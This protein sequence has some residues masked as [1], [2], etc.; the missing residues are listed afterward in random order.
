MGATKT[1]KAK[2]KR[3]VAPLSGSSKGTKHKSKNKDKKG[4]KSSSAKDSHRHQHVDSKPKNT[5]GKQQRIRKSSDPRLPVTLLSGFLGAGKTTLL[6][7]IL[8]NKEHG[9]KC[10]VIVND[11]SSL[12]ID[13]QI[14]S[15]HKLTRTEEKLVQ[16]QNGCICCTLRGDLLEEVASIAE[17][18]GIDYLLIE[19]T[20]ISEPMQVAETFTYEF[21]EHAAAEE[22]QGNGR[23]ASLLKKGGLPKIARLDTCVSVVDALNVL[24]DFNTTDFITDRPQEA[25]NGEV[26]PSDERNVTDL[27]VDQIEFS[28]I[29][30]VNKT[31]LASKETV[32]KVLQLIKTL[33]PRAKIIS[34]VKCQVPLTEILNTHRFSFEE[35]IV[36]AGW[37]QSL[38]ESTMRVTPNGQTKNIPKPE[39]EEYGIS[40]FVYQR[41]RPFHPERLW[42]IIGDKFVVIQN[43]YEGLNGDDDD[44]E[45]NDEEKMDEDKEEEQEEEEDEEAQPQLNPK[46]R[47]ESKN[48]SPAFAA[49]HAVQRILLARDEEYVVW[50]MESSRCYVHPEEEWADGNKEAVEV[51]KQDFMGEWGDRRQEIVFIGG[52]EK[53][54]QRYLIEKE[55]DGALLTD[56]EWEEWQKIMLSKDLNDDE[57][58]EKLL[59]MFRDGFEDWLDPLNPPEG[60]EVDHD[61]DHHH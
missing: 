36:G 5:K 41:R 12:N 47:L 59:Q 54:M 37:L 46:A 13:A 15:N 28:D 34:T 38:K 50:R 45:G 9:L 60:F 7:Y 58:E 20:G 11:M 26:D 1:A 40:N 33:N 19:S 52:G 8:S 61:H 10:A 55:L 22:E 39:T 29:I 53:P 30:L 32:D 43:E 35:A 57:K 6:K 44:D 2:V 42:K 17:A 14:V 27:L 56:E 23:L 24:N 48:A 49:C 51:I 31:D 3:I 18:G 21:A 25:A 4:T 16:M